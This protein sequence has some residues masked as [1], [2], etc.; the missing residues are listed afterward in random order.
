MITEGE[1]N[2]SFQTFVKNNQTRYL[3]KTWQDKISARMIE[4]NNYQ[5]TGNL[6]EA[7]IFMQTVTHLPVSQIEVTPKAEQH[8]IFSKEM[9]H[10]AAYAFI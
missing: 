5:A 10:P 7:K 2:M 9:V 4:K 3:S 1:T 8:I 6:K